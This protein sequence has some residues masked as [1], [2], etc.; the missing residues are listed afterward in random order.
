MAL[1][2]TAI[3]GALINGLVWMLLSLLILP[4]SWAMLFGVLAAI[5]ALPVMA[6]VVLAQNIPVTSDESHQTEPAVR[7]PAHPL[8]ETQDVTDTMSA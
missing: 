3:A 2:L 7:L 1:R 8:Y 4:T 5:G 6:A